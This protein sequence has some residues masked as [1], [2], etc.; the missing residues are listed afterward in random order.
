VLEVMAKPAA[1]RNDQVLGTDTHIVMLPSPG[2][3]VPTPMPMPFSGT[4]SDNLSPD[5]LIE[6]MPAAVV[7]S[8]A[9]NLPQHIAMGGPFQNPPKNKATIKVGTS[10]VLINNKNA[11][12][13]GSQ[14]ETCNDPADLPNGQI[15]STSNVLVGE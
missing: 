9:D 15:I 5:V 7:G 2:G 1:K 3:P 4:L 12:H 11:A 10:K 6:N 8:T 13:A 14:V